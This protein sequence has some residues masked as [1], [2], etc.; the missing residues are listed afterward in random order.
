MNLLPPESTWF[1]VA[2]F[3]VAALGVLLGSIGLVLTIRRDRQQGR[4]NLRLS[5]AVEG[6]NFALRITNSER[7]AVSAERAGLA[8]EKDSGSLTPFG[9]DRIRSRVVGGALHGDSPLPQPLAP[10]DPGYVVKAPLY[11]VRGAFFPNVPEWAWVEDAY[12]NV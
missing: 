6:D 5:P 11:A 2:T 1:D 8:I 3:G 7:R 4:V 9:W 10:G 12:G